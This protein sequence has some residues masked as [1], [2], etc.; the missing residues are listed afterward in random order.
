LGLNR[1]FHP[2]FVRQYADLN[3]VIENAVKM[4]V[5][6]VREKNFPSQEESY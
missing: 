4:Y 6:D 3:T 1:E 5:H 2:R